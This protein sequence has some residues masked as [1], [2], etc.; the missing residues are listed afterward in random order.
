MTKII[1]MFLSFLKV[2]LLL[3]CFVLSFFIIFSMYQRLEKN[4]LEAIFNFIPFALLFILFSINFIFKQKSVNSCLFYNVT[5]CFV[6]IVILFAAFRTFFDPNMVV[7]IRLGYNINF[8]YFADFIAP[9]RAMLYILCAANILLMI[10]GIFDKK[11][12]EV[13]TK[14]VV[15]KEEVKKVEDQAEKK[16]VAKKTTRSRK[17]VET[18][19][20]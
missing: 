14:V 9:M 13:E 6:F 11:K 17:K 12:V 16:D 1:N 8:N 5:C 3:I 7:M 20:V 18:K 10:L 15:E 2:L 19:E 4:Y